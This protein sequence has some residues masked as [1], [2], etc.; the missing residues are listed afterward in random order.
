M[1]RLTDHSKR[2]S[3]FKMSRLYSRMMNQFRDFFLLCILIPIVFFL[4]LETSTRV[5]WAISTEARFGY[6]RNYKWNHDYEFR[7]GELRQKK[8]R[9]QEGKG[10]DLLIALNSSK[11]FN[12]STTQLFSD[13]PWVD[14]EE[15]LSRSLNSILNNPEKRK[16][17]IQTYQ[18]HVRRQN[19]EITS[20]LKIKKR[21]KTQSKRLVRLM[22]ETMFPVKT[23]FSYTYYSRHNPIDIL[24]YGNKSVISIMKKVPLIRHRDAHPGIT[25]VA[26]GG[27]T[28]ECAGVN[29]PQCWTAYLQKKLDERHSA[30]PSFPKSKVI[31]LGRSAGT[32][33]D[34]QRALLTYLQKNPNSK[35][36]YILWYE[37]LN[38]IYYRVQEPHLA[39]LVMQG[40][41]HNDKVNLKN[42]DREISQNYK[43]LL[44]LNQ[45]S[46][47]VYALLRIRDLL[48][49]SLPPERAKPGKLK[50]GTLVIDR[51]EAIRKTAELNYQ[52][53]SEI[54]H[55][56]AKGVFLF[57]IPLPRNALQRQYHFDY[58]A[59]K[60]L[61]EYLKVFSKRD[62]HTFGDVAQKIESE[63][64]EDVFSVDRVHLNAYGNFLLAHEIY[65]SILPTIKK[66]FLNN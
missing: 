31:N 53:L 33:I 14:D 4:I 57:S 15:T 44:F 54:K 2:A 20:L 56:A 16:L 17:F 8:A 12:H 55:L 63:K 40:S 9:D 60:K 27:S 30:T 42:F 22:M 59:K 62:G 13:L 49:K 38:D 65:E 25:I 50:E 47:F 41:Y 36:D 21:T 5:L 45:N 10:T 7:V 11:Q 6:F 24:F 35:I 37:G 43:I 48:F 46:A 28:T 58:E 26:L 23:K 52:R 64:V 34:S 3:A 19:P 18:N 1:I 39:E 61:F 66:D 29:P 32:S 51:E